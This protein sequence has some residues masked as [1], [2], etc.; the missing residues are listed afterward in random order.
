MTNCYVVIC[1]YSSYPMT[2][3]VIH[4]GHFQ[5]SSYPMTILVIYLSHFQL[6]HLKLLNIGHLSLEKTTVTKFYG[7]LVTYLSFCTSVAGSTS[8]LHVI[9]N[10]LPLTWGLNSTQSIQGSINMH[11]FNTNHPTFLQ[12]IVENIIGEFENE[13]Y[14]EFS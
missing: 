12:V 5:L 11:L 4:I 9:D 1:L 6:G 7:H 14:V 3:F 2:K 10:H 13:W 8:F